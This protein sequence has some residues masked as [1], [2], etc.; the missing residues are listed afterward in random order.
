MGGATAARWKSRVK[1]RKRRSAADTPTWIVQRDVVEPFHAHSQQPL[2]TTQLS[3]QQRPRPATHHGVLR[4]LHPRQARRPHA[5]RDVRRPLLHNYRSAHLSV[6]RHSENMR[7]TS[8][9]SLPPCC[10]PIFPRVSRSHLSCNV[11]AGWTTSPTSTSS[12]AV[13]WKTTPLE[14][15][16]RLRFGILSMHPCTL[17]CLQSPERITRKHSDS[18]VQ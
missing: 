9:P 4:G 6:L 7:G 1:E 3:Q 16:L 14:G 13:W 11:Q 18:S 8:P 15:R 5:R 12:A 2:S 17:A 10:P